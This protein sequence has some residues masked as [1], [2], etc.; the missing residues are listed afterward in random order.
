MIRQAAIVLCS[1]T[2]AAQVPQPNPFD[3]AN[4]AYFQARQKGQYDVAT[5]QREEMN[6]LLPTLAPD[7]PQFGGRAQTLAQLYDGDG[8]SVKGRAVLEGALSRADGAKAPGQVRVS[9]LLALATFWERD[10]NLLKSLAFLER[11]VAVA[12]QTPDTVEP[13]RNA[14]SNARQI[15][16]FQSR[17]AFV[18]A[19]PGSVISRLGR[20]SSISPGIDR[21]ALYTRLADLYQRLGRPDQAAAVVAKMKA[22]PAQPNNLAL[23]QYYQQHGDLDQ[24]AAIYKKQIEEPG[25][26][27]LQ[28]IFPAQSLAGIYEQQ[29]RPDDAAAVLRQ[30]IATLDATGQPEMTSALRQ[31]LATLLYQSGHVEAADQ[32]FPLPADNGASGTVSYAQYLGNT[33]RAAQGETILADYLTAHPSLSANERR[34]VMGSLAN[35]ARAAGDSKN[36][37][38]YSREASQMLA[39]TDPPPDVVRIEPV[40]R[41]AQTEA[42]TG[43]IPE[44]IVLTTQA[45]AQSGTARDRDALTRMAPSV[46]D[47]ISSKAPQQADELYRNVSATAQSWSADTMQPWLAVAA[48]YPRF[49]ISQQRTGEVPPAIERYRAALKIASGADTGWM[50]EPLRLTIELERIRN[51]PAAAI[52][53]AQNL[54]ALD[55]ALSGPTSEQS[56]RAMETLADVYRSTFDSARAL[57]A[58]LQTITIADAVFPAND[59]RRVQARTNA[60]GLL[61][62]ERRL[63]EAE[64]MV[65]EA[66]ALRD[67]T[68]RGTRDALPQML[69]QIHALKKAR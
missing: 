7:E 58:F 33:Q 23:A 56:Y 61:I 16:G 14:A 67:P 5:A 13:Q 24:A 50:E 6:R 41:K 22:L 45:I 19:N 57:P 47:S 54:V 21:A 36:A 68:Q 15:V 64:Q 35:L 62:A 46:A 48:S 28:T 10:R 53:A 17:E 37:E 25:A 8:M 32:A 29:K 63:D 40:L 20:A 30:A 44:A 4:Q 39:L 59:R 69:D 51:S 65:V 55:E 34:N 1:V 52:P 42:N 38:A 60:A 18:F 2:A 12:E 31:R 3:T 27:P 11:A 49:L 43:N 26:N 66:M 9:L